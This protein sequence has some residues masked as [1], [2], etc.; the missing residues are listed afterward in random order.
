MPKSPVRAVILAAALAVPAALLL[1]GPGPAE[2]ASTQTASCVDGGGVRWDARAVWGGTYVDAG[3]T[4]TSIKD[5]GWTTWGRNVRTDSRMRTYDGSG[6]RLE[7]VDWTGAFDYRSG[8]AFRSQDPRNPPSAGRP[9]I[10]LTLGVDGDGHGD[11]T[12]TFTQPVRTTPTPTPAPTASDPQRY[13]AD[14][15]AR[16]NTERSAQ[17][18]APL[19]AESC[20]DRYAE[21]HAATMAAQQRMVHQDLQ[22]I[23]SACGLNRVGENVAYGFPSGEAVMTAWLNSPGHSANIV[24]PGFRLLGVGAVQAADGTWYACQVFGSRP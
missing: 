17:G 16:T 23:L 2:A 14:V 13:E 10:T 9:R 21:A 3:V 19:T 22:P 6:R 5:V 18:L 1:P 15:A 8:T 12:V 7:Q 24:N 20:V 4:R 11:C